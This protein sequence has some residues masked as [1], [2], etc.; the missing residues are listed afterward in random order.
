MIKIGLGAVVYQGCL[1]EVEG[2][3]FQVSLHR[4]TDKALLKM[5]SQSKIINC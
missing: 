5:N 4:P 3:S 1:I 2:K